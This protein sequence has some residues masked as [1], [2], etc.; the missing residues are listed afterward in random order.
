MGVY[1]SYPKFINNYWGCFIILA[2][3]VC[4]IFG[5]M[6][7]RVKIAELLHNA[8]RYLATRVGKFP[9]CRWNAKYWWIWRVQLSNQIA[10]G[11]RKVITFSES[12]FAVYF[13]NLRAYTLAIKHGN[14]NAPIWQPVYSMY[15]NI[16]TKVGISCYFCI[17]E[18]CQ[19][20]ST[21]IT[22]TDSAQVVHVF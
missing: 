10:W 6:I 19:F 5:T 11:V 15:L 13:M 17:M 1:P 3:P 20:R 2:L 18:L 16:L 22:P 12:E 9:I 8:A 4:H 7:R 21:I 14:W